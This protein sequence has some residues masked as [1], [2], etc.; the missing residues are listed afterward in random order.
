MALYGSK[1]RL[2]TQGRPAGSMTTTVRPG[3]APMRG[4]MQM[5]AVGGLSGQGYRG[6]AMVNPNVPMT[7]YWGGVRGVGNPSQYTSGID[8]VRGGGHY[9]QGIPLVKAGEYYGRGIDIVNSG[10]SYFGGMYMPKSGASYTNGMFL[11]GQGKQYFNNKTIDLVDKAGDYTGLE[12]ET[13]RMMARAGGALGADL[14]AQGLSGGPIALMRQQAGVSEAVGN[15]ANEINADKF[16]RESMIQEGT[17]ARQQGVMAGDIARSQQDLGKRQLTLSGDVARSQADYQKRS[18]ILSGDTAR[19]Q[20]Q[21]GRNQLILSGDTARQQGA[22]GRNQLALSGDQARMQGQ[23]G[24]NQLGLGAATQNS[25]MALAR[26]QG[27][28]GDQQ[29]GLGQSLA[30]NQLNSGNY[31]NWDNNRLV[32]EG[33]IAGNNQNPATG[34]QPGGGRGMFGK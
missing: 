18:G 26:A 12:A 15:L 14:A 19:M 3:G 4:S 11:P 33:I 2:T 32:G 30:Y 20:G 8:M 28:A 6:P 7:D 10:Q 31:W 23:L 22:L 21:L 29:F 16:G 34:V 1:N 5:G 25:Q 9:A 27:R 24:R 13:G 17:L